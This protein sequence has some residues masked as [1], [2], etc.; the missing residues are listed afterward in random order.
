MLSSQEQKEREVET[1]LLSNYASTIR[2]H[3]LSVHI[4]D[5]STNDIKKSTTTG[6]QKGEA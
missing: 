1:L 5:L 6:F 3:R 4:E 2:L